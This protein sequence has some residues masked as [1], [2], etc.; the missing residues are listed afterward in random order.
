MIPTTHPHPLQKKPLF[1][2]CVCKEYSREGPQL[3]GSTASLRKNSTTPESLIPACI[4]LPQLY[5]ASDNPFFAGNDSYRS[6]VQGHC[7]I[8]NHPENRSVYAVVFIIR[9]SICSSL[10]AK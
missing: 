6:G 9:C 3:L 2:R 7:P 1:S 10:S 4:W 5:L 8:K